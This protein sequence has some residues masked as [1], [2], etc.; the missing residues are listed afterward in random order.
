M[1]AWLGSGIGPPEVVAGLRRFSEQLDEL[2]PRP[3]IVLAHNKLDVR[4][5]EADH[6]L[7]HVMLNGYQL[8][9]EASE[10]KT[11]AMA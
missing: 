8:T 2:L 6:Q 5:L 11:G 4:S 9:L 1:W 10:S 3:R 7:L